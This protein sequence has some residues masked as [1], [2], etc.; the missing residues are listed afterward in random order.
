MYVSIKIRG[1][2]ISM[3]KIAF[4]ASMLISCAKSGHIE[5]P[6][7]PNMYDMSDFVGPS[8]VATNSPCLDG[9]LINLGDSCKTMVEI[10][11]NGVITLIQC[12]EAKNQ[13]SPWDKHTFM[14][15]QDPTLGVPPQ[16]QPFCSDPMVTIYFK[17]RF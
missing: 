10:I 8:Y 14:A 3:F 13:K 9:L 16:T 17:E 2:D 7:V 11:D 4:F 5:A 1:F 6:S 12:H 15:V